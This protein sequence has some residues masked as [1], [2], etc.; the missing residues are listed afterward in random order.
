MN[1]PIT[2]LVYLAVS[3]VV[4]VWVAHTLHSRG[5]V[6][7][8]DTFKGN[9]TLADSI[10]DLLIVGFYLVNVGYVL[11]ALKYGA[12]PTDFTGTIEF[13]ATKIGLVM[14][15]LGLMHYFNLAVF[16]KLTQRNRQSSHSL[17]RR[18]GVSLRQ[19]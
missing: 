3:I 10:N 15:I 13:L 4:T 12:K 5:R 8:V 6:F 2:Y 14:V 19:N 16:S 7:L 18:S 11:L 1:M 9:E 17:P